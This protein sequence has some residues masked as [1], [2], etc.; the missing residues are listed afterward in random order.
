MV[1]TRLK[2]FEPKCG[3]LIDPIVDHLLTL[4]FA[5]QNSPQKW[6]KLD[7]TPI[8]IALLDEHTYKH[9]NPKNKNTTI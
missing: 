3:P 8:L 1:H 2:K 7:E 4:L 5:P 6:Q 9:Q